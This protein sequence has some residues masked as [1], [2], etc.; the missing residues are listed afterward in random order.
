MNELKEMK[1]KKELQ[2]E[3]DA[4]DHPSHQ[5]T[6][7]SGFP[8]CAFFLTRPVAGDVVGASVLLSLLA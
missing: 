6:C 4:I 7:L 8:Y 2:K 1:K 3:R 5:P